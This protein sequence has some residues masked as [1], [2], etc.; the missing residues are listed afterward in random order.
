MRN[1]SYWFLIPIGRISMFDP[2]IKIESRNQGAEKVMCWAGM[3]YGKVYTCSRTTRTLL[4]RPTWRC[5]PMSSGHRSSQLPQEEIII[6]SKTMKPGLW[7]TGSP[8]TSRRGSSE[9][10][11]TS[12]SCQ[13]PWLQPLGFLVL[14]ATLE[15]V[16]RLKPRTVEE[17]TE[18]VYDFAEV[19]DEEKSS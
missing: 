14:G 6:F 16:K 3:V 11:W 5:C 2:N 12:P 18:I 4:G 7:G 13:E 17:L 8:P 9:G 1:G 19:M 10:S 15:E